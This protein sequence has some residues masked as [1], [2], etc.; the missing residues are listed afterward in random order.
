MAN[1]HSLREDPYRTRRLPRSSSEPRPA[2]VWDRD[3]INGKRLS[4]SMDNHCL[5]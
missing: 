3:F 1:H 2:P 4:E 5:H